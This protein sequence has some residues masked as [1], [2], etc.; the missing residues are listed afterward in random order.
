M[1]IPTAQPLPA[2]TRRLTLMDI[3]RPAIRHLAMVHHPA[4]AMHRRQAMELLQMPM[5]TE[6]PP[7]MGHPQAMEHLPRDMVHH[8]A[9]GH[10]MALQLPRRLHQ[11][12]ERLGA[13][14]FLVFYSS[15]HF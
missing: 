12:M 11:D 5:A 8:L 4:M 9:M 6:H 2:A 14:P 1:P 7:A 10:P 13:E 15:C 3:R